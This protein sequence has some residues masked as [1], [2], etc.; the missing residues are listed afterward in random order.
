MESRTLELIA[1]GSSLGDSYIFNLEPPKG[2]VHL[3]ET[4]VFGLILRPE[5]NSTSPEVLRFEKGSGL[6][7]PDGKWDGERRDDGSI[8]FGISLLLRGK[9][10]PSMLKIIV[11]S[12]E[13]RATLAFTEVPLEI[14][15]S[16]LD[17]NI[18]GWP[19]RWDGT[20]PM[21][22]GIELTHRGEG[23][24]N[25]QSS[26]QILDGNGTILMKGDAAETI[27]KHNSIVKTIIDPGRL[28]DFDTLSVRVELLM[29]G[30]HQD[31]LILG[32]IL[33]L[34]DKKIK[35][36]LPGRIIS[37]E[38]FSVI[39]EIPE[40]QPLDGLELTLGDLGP[41]V[42]EE[43][44]G[45]GNNRE[46]LF[47]VPEMNKGMVPLV[48]KLGDEEVSRS[49]VFVD[50]MEIFH[51]ISLGFE[52]TSVS[53]GEKVGI[54]LDVKMTSDI[55][56]LKVLLEFNR[57]NLPDLDLGELPQNGKLDHII[58]LPEDLDIGDIGGKLRFLKGEEEVG[59]EAHARFFTIRS[60]SNL[61]LEVKLPGH[62][63]MERS[64]Q[65]LLPG[66]TITSSREYSVAS[67]KYL[68]SGRVLIKS[69]ERIIPEKGEG[70]ELASRIILV[71]TFL[72]TLTRPDV[73]KKMS[74]S[75]EHLRK[76]TAL[77]LRSSDGVRDTK[78][79][80]F[81]GYF[82]KHIQNGTDEPAYKVHST[83][84]KDPVSNLSV[85]L[86]ELLADDGIGPR[87]DPTS[88][89]RDL[90]EHI[91]K[92]MKGRD[93]NFDRGLVGKNLMEI[94]KRGRDALKDIQSLQKG[95]V[96]DLE[97]ASG[98]LKRVCFY[99]IAL[100]LVRAEVFSR[101]S[102]PV[103]TAW[104]QIRIER[105]RA[106][107]G[108]IKSIGDTVS[109]IS[110]IWNAS[111]QRWEAYRKNTVARCRFASFDGLDINVE[112][113]G[114]SGMSGDVWECVVSISSKERSP[115]SK[116]TPYLSLPRGGWSLEG[117]MSTREGD[118]L[119]LEPFIVGEGSRNEI[120]LRVRAPSVTSS[121]DKALLYLHPGDIHLEEEP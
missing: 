80:G 22:I 29:D 87:S 91:M 94:S 112:N 17:V 19:L 111:K 78:D 100:S 75:L 103:V 39:L 51:R 42:P 85:V 38:E 118:N 26:I 2:K 43:I 33:P 11:K 72:E 113:G 102:D 21:E 66:E 49:P 34:K 110:D 48:L 115:R 3:D 96:I 10:G 88:S 121:E 65:I 5:G 41:F 81:L 37:G 15:S 25:V 97:S 47:R 44:K 31:K 6:E 24:V 119:I 83:D 23:K 58:D 4:T 53:P 106:I 93:S 1:E 95:S 73:H 30:E 32:A 89:L 18:P 67:I 70:A 84:G 35:A 55:G 82:S 68:N 16:K 12:E 99:L 71:D 120:T 79:T 40:G 9:K 63:D 90:V 7:G 98:A 56:P 114:F 46:A 20:S 107:K 76:V 61:G 116:L 77:L 92:G 104:D 74:S 108:S 14:G 52:P 117:P 57:K 105:Q 54:K 62:L 28:I 60:R 109:M 64:E 69:R 45:E 27:V 36:G 50:Q 86:K 13:F 8:H 59:G 101:W